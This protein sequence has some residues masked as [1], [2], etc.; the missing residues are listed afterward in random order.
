[1][2]RWPGSLD[3]MPGGDHEGLL[4]LLLEVG[5]IGVQYR[6]SSVGFAESSVENAQK[7][8]GLD[9]AQDGAILDSVVARGEFV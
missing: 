3:G 4:V 2:W 9:A 8:G 6:V 7:P 1:M 5:L